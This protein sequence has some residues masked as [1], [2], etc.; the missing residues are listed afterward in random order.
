MILLVPDKIERLIFFFRRCNNEKLCSY[1]FIGCFCGINRLKCDDTKGQ[2]SYIRS[3]RLL[4]KK[5]KTKQS[6]TNEKKITPKLYYSA[7][8]DIIEKRVYALLS[9]RAN[10][11]KCNLLNKYK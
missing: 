2:I 1:Q 11:L 8:P 7:S 3:I 4:Q 5:K 9:L 6:T 10:V